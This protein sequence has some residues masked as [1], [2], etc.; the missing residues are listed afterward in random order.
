LSDYNSLKAFLN[1]SSPVQLDP[2]TIE[3]TAKVDAFPVPQVKI[4][5]VCDQAVLA[6]TKAAF[7]YV[8]IKLYPALVICYRQRQTLDGNLDKAP[9]KPMAETETHIPLIRGES[10]QVKAGSRVLIRDID[11]TLNEN[12]IVSIIGPNGAGKTTLIRTLLGITPISQ[13]TLHIRPGLRVGYVPQKLAFDSTLPLTVDRFLGLRTGASNDEI[14]K[15][16]EDTGASALATTFMSDLSGGETQRVLLARALLREPELLVLDE[17]ASGLDITG[18][19]DLYNLIRKIRRERGCGILLVSHDLHMVM[20]ATDQV[21]C[22]NKHVCCSG[23]PDSVAQHPEFIELFGEE[24]AKVMAPYTHIH[25]HE[26]SVG[27]EVEGE[28]HSHD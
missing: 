23:K 5:L 20:A 27:G 18:Q 25:D 26:H 13:G 2:G 14:I 28:A 6:S 9:H 22:I 15:A 3:Y 7:S 16:L 1:G 4:T 12:E 8:V 19:T 11:I 17:P 24:A 10:L 21:L